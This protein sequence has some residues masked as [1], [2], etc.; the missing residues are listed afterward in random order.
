MNSRA[1]HQVLLRG[2]VRASC[3]EN[4]SASQET[5]TTLR[6][7]PTGLPVVDVMEDMNHAE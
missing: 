2:M 1:L 7:V 5:D 4:M 6:L 3:G